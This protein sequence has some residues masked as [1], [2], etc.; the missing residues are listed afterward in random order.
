MYRNGCADFRLNSV[1]YNFSFTDVRFRALARVVSELMKFKRHVF[2]YGTDVDKKE[3]EKCATNEDFTGMSRRRPVI[4]CYVYLFMLSRQRCVFLCFALP[5][6]PPIAVGRVQYHVTLHHRH[7]LLVFVTPPSPRGVFF[8]LRPGKRTK[9]GRSRFVP[10]TFDDLP[11][12]KH[13]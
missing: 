12:Q 5:P 4:L 1:Y 10:K 9:S 6:P 3:I 8:V 2:R 11:V 13:H 7:P